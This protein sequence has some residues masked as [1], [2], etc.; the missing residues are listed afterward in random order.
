MTRPRQ[1][2]RPSYFLL[3]TSYFLLVGCATAPQRTTIRYSPPSV[4]PTQ[5]KISDAQGHAKA[6]KVAIERAQKLAPKIPDLIEAL[7]TAHAEND[8]LTYELLTAQTSLSGLEK[9]TSTQTDLLNQANIDKNEAIGLLD[10]EKAKTKHVVSQRNELFLI[11]CAAVAWIFRTPLLWLA[12]FLVG[13]I[14]KIAIA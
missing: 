9:Q 1:A 13:L 3:L 5:Q 8:A 7:A 2:V 10:I 14:S 6:A 4:I 12:K 11:L